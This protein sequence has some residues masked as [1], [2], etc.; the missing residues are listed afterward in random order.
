M[1]TPRSQILNPDLLASYNQPQEDL[2]NRKSP[3]FSFFMHPIQN[4]FPAFTVDLRKIHEMI[5]SDRYKKQTIKLRSF[6][7]KNQARNY[8]AF[9][10]NYATFSGI[11][12]KRSNDAIKQHSGLLTLDIDHVSNLEEI[13]QLLLK[14]A[15]L[16][17]ELLFTSP[18]GDGLK[19]I[20][21]ID[22]KKETHENYF[23]A[24]RNY[25]KYTYQIEVDKSGKDVA[26]AC[27]IPH[28]PE[29]FINPKYQ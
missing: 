12:E 26:R 29:V 21:S 25:L 2:L 5:R 13:K 3:K 9:H 8:K 17:T 27:F 18:S 22:L 1:S 14:D 24:I 19:W 4:V 16:E 11:F 20:I 23:Q 7:D 28:D 15:F 10:F 6:Q